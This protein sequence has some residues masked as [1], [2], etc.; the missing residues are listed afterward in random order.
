MAEPTTVCAEKVPMTAMR[1][2]FVVGIGASAGGLEALELLVSRLEKNSCPCVVLQH[3]SPTHDNLLGE[4]LGRRTAMKVVTVKDGDRVEAATIYVAPPGAELMLSDGQLRVVQP[5]AGPSLHP[6][7]T[8]FCSLAEQLGPA[9]VGVVLSGAG[10]DGTV[11]LRAIKDEGGSTFVQHPQSAAHPGMPQSAIG[12]GLAD[13]TLEP[14]EIGAELARLSAHPPL[15]RRPPPPRL[16]PQLLARVFE[17]LRR[18]CG[19]DFSSYKPSTIERRIERRMALQRIEQPRDYLKFLEST[20]SEV[21]VLYSDLLIGVTAFFRDGEPF[22]ALKSIVFPRLFDSRPPGPLRIWVPGCA[23]GEEAYSMAICLLEYL[24]DRAAAFKIQIFATDLDERAIIRARAGLY[25]RS[26]ENEVSPER[27]E[28]FFVSEDAGHRV[29]PEVRE[30]VVFARHN[31][32]KDPSFGRLDLI[33]CR[34]VLIYLQPQLQNKVLRGFHWSLNPNGCLLLGTSECVGDCSDLF[35]LSDRKLKIYAKKI[36]PSPSVYDFAAGSERKVPAEHVLPMPM[37]S[38]QQLADRKV[39][40][41]YGPPGLLI[42]ERFEVIQFRGN[43]GPY[44]APTPGLASL[45]L[46]KL[47]RHELLSGLRMAVQR[48]FAEFLPHSSD[49]MQLWRERQL[50]SVVFDVLPIHDAGTER[51][52]LLVLFRE[53]TMSPQTQA[54]AVAAQPAYSRE[55]LETAL[56]EAEATN[57]ALQSSNQHLQGS[58]EELQSSNEE[59]QSLNEE[60]Q[61]S[62]EEMQAINEE[63]STVNNELQSR[64][65][66]VLVAR[67]RARAL[68]GKGR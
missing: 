10:D 11:G 55:Y 4:L 39:V 18:H 8:L 15:D 48:G 17:Q 53:P 61:T 40:E 16:D 46:F 65:L 27:L 38:V 26:I 22:E 37:I 64:M 43:T 35:S 12:A 28:R 60:L 7:D 52:C 62:R 1:A 41:K 23:T 30:Q 47:V 57:E 63:L 25:P 21:E 51:R 36:S 50:V 58:N 32:G 42:N 19:I 2:A 13:H 33:S 20:P 66:Q 54:I 31:L 49:P 44:L 24:G 45:E 5:A 3:L 56:T 59:L 34:N 14:A 9:A 29:R 6:I 68:E 67:D